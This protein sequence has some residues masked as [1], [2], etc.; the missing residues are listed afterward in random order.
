MNWSKTLRTACVA[1]VF[2][3]SAAEAQAQTQITQITVR[4]KTRLDTHNSCSTF[5][6]GGPTFGTN[7]DVYLGI[8]GR[9]FRLDRPTGDFD[10]GSDVTFILGESTN[11]VNADRNDPRRDMPVFL[12]AP[13]AFPVYLRMSERIDDDW[14]MEF[15]EVRIFSGTGAAMSLRGFWTATGRVFGREFG[16][17][18]PL[19]R[20]M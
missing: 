5:T 13:F 7:S 6:C 17:Q 2:V 16:Y 12:T 3:V 19:T 10:N 8:A 18:V 1:A 20:A 14:N 9:E 4:V 15:V 11:V